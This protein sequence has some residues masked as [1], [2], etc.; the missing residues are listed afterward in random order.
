VAVEIHSKGKSDS[1]S[2]RSL[3]EYF[4]NCAY[5]L[6]KSSLFV[7]IHIFLLVSL[8]LSVFLVYKMATQYL[9]IIHYSYYRCPS[10]LSRGGDDDYLNSIRA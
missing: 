7:K 4:F 6:L 5:F 10:E 9:G 1:K 3:R 2:L 8:F